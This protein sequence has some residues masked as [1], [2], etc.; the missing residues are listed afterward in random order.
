MKYVDVEIRV[1]LVANSEDGSNIGYS[2]NHT[3]DYFII[4]KSEMCVWDIQKSYWFIIYNTQ[5]R[6][7]LCNLKTETPNFICRIYSMAGFVSEQR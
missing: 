1:T 4:H 6:F 5:I 3:V 2:R 7:F